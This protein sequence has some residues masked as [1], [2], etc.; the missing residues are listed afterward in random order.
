MQ[1][2]GIS[3]SQA[4][5]AAHVDHVAHRV[6]HAAGAQEQQR[7]EE[8]V[9]EQVEHAG[10]DAQQRA[11]AQ[12]QEHVAQLADRGIGQHALQIGLREGDQRRRA[13][14]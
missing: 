1:V 2:I 12:A 6:H 8:R 3:S 10:D 14:P 9:R 4:A 13:A 5:E 11:G 7:L